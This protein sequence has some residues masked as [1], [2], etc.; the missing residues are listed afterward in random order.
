MN[1]CVLYTSTTHDGSD[2]FNKSI[3][4]L[5]T[6]NRAPA[7]R[8]LAARR[9][10][11]FAML[12]GSRFPEVTDGLAEFFFDVDQEFLYYLSCRRTARPE[13]ILGDSFSMR[14]AAISK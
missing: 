6:G 11:L 1:A 12:A 14:R 7:S 2:E 3:R 5:A 4:M 9:R 10:A 8:I 13:N